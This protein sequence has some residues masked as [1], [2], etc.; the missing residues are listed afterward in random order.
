MRRRRCAGIAPAARS[1]GRHPGSLPFPNLPEGTDTL[2]RI[3]HFVVVVQ[4]NRSLKTVPRDARSRPRVRPRPP[5]SSDDTN[6]DPTG[7][8]VPPSGDG[9]SRPATSP[10]PGT[11]ATS[12]RARAG[13][14]VH[15]T[16]RQQRLVDRGLHGRG[17][18]LLTRWPAFPVCD[19]YSARC[20]RRP[21]RTAAS[22][23]PERPSGIAT[24]DSSINGILP[25]GT[26]FDRLDAH[27]MAGRA[28]PP[29]CP[30]SM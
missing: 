18:P 28:T 30:S 22:C 25:N 11:P 10:R 9:R 27:G 3:E 26:V 7:G 21:T 20:W 15:R 8:S 17:D 5:R 23:W 4:E 6:P 29:T 12:S 19:R 14:R 24:V 1:Q 13:R 16:R 2:P